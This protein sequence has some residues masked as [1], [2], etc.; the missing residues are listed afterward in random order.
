MA[1]SSASPAAFL[2]WAKKKGIF[3]HPDVDPLRPTADMGGVGVFAKKFLPAGTVVLETPL[4][5]AISPYSDPHPCIPSVAV[6]RSAPPPPPPTTASS[7]SSS[8]N[9]N[10]GGSQATRSLMSRDA[11][12]AV[13]LQ[14]LAEVSMKKRSSF[15][16]WLLH[17]PPMRA[18]LFHLTPEEKEIFG[19]GSTEPLSLASSSRIR[20]WSGLAQQLMEMRVEE[21]WNEALRDYILPHPDVWAVK[22]ANFQNF[23][24]CLAHVSSRNFHRDELTGREGP[25]LL[26]GLDFLNHSAAPNTNFEV[27]GGGRKHETSFTVVTNTVT[28]AGEQIFASYGSIGTARFAVEFQFISPDAVQKNLCRFSC[29]QLGEMAALLVLQQRSGKTENG[30]LKEKEDIEEVL[31]DTTQRVELLQRIGL[32]F[33]EGLYLKGGGGIDVDRQVAIQT[34]PIG[35]DLPPILPSPPPLSSSSLSWPAEEQQREWERFRAVV[36]LLLQPTTE[37]FTEMFHHKAS[38]HWRAP[39][40]T[41][42]QSSVQSM[43][44]LKLVAARDTWDRFAK[45]VDHRKE[46]ELEEV[47]DDAVVKEERLELVRQALYAEEQ[48]LVEHLRKLR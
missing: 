47:A 41:F 17:C 10:N 40:D 45:A 27:R 39:Q 2:K 13:V 43:L 32:L 37:A 35:A 18:H 11:M 48:V 19:V 44:E 22:H 34:L 6:L 36:Y 7:S 24:L 42:G 16:P 21:R 8:S 46:K 23:C 5:A 30:E 26:P 20:R 28:K 15:Y 1:E 29:E 25:Y 4:S 12:L 9:K 33:D 14:L 31:K 38:A 3:I